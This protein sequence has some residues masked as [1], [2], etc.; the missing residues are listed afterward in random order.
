M[1]TGVAFAAATAL[2]LLPAWIGA[3][4]RNN[5]AIFWLNLLLGWSVIGW[6]AALVWALTEEGAP[7]QTPPQT[8]DIVAPAS[9]VAPALPSEPE[10]RMNRLK[11]LRDRRML[12]Q[13]EF[14][15]LVSRSA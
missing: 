10:A 8:A 5:S 6:V 4:K 3:K 11:D 14:L 1:L 15:D 13:E 2:Y 7:S 9:H 12:T